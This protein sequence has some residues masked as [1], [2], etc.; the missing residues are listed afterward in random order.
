[1]EVL[2]FSWYTKRNASQTVDPTNWVNAMLFELVNTL[3]KDAANNNP[4]TSDLDLAG[5]DVVVLPDDGYGRPDPYSGQIPNVVAN[6]P[7]PPASPPAPGAQVPQ[8]IAP[9]PANPPAGLPGNSNVPALA[10]QNNNA[11]GGP[12]YYYIFGS[13]QPAAGFFQGTWPAPIQ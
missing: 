4:D 9:P 2:A 11:D 8:P 1:N 10:A 13:P 5:W 7:P 3:T 6:L 12:R